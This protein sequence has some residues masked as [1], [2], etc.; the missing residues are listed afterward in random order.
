MTRI[1]A[2]YE[3][4]AYIGYFC[5]KIPRMDKFLS[6]LFSMRWAS[7]GLIAFLVAIGL[8]TFIESIYGIQ[9]AKISIYNATWFEGL[10]LYLTLALVSNIFRYKMFS[11][12]KI[13]I[14]SFHLS[15]IVILAGAAVTRYI[16]FEGLMVIREGTNS[17]FIYT[18]DPYFLINAQ[19]ITQKNGATALQAWKTYLS[20]FNNND[21]EY[22]TNIGKKEISIRYIDFMSD[23]VDSLQVN[24]KFKENALELVTEGKKSNY[25]TEEDVLMVGTTPFYFSAQRPSAPNQAPGVYLHVK[26]GKTWIYP[27][28]EIKALPMTEMEKV[29]ASGQAPS[30][31][32]YINYPLNEWSE[33]KT[34]SLYIVGGQ[35]VVFKRLI[36]HAKKMLVKAPVKK[37]GKDYLTVELSDGKAS[38]KNP[39]GRWHG[40]IP[41]TRAFCHERRCLS[42]R[43]WLH[44]K[45]YSLLRALPR[46]HTRQISRF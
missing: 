45:K 15:F 9:A 34:F 8:A 42:I 30:D 6:S 2:F 7:V 43:I 40:S 10:L 20:E 29:R 14:L 23:R 19:D 16:S 18:S 35:Q 38:K 1:R 12:E 37:S 21:F 33:F 39:F 46:I 17:N 26:D 27:S 11:R 22:Q 13:A 41:Q 3:C 4:C 28:I 44:S 24:Q 32:L 5:Q 25:L 36:P 31:S